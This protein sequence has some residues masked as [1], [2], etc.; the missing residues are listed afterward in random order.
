MF[1]EMFK[2]N[3]NVGGNHPSIDLVINAN[4]EMHIPT[5]LNVTN[6]NL[7]SDIQLVHVSCATSKRAKR[8]ETKND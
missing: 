6:Y 3:E 8:D 4:D 2:I 7:A 5:W 1:D